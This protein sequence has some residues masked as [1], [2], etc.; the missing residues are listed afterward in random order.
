MA[1]RMVCASWRMVAAVLLLGLLLAGASGQQPQ[2]LQAQGSGAAE[3]E[4]SQWGPCGGLNGPDKRDA[5][6]EGCPDGYAC[7]RQD[8]FYWQVMNCALACG[9]GHAVHDQR[10]R[11]RRQSRLVFML[12]RTPPNTSAV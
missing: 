8:Q 2:Q 10:M 3:D 11:C 7:I 9:D 6:G 4:A 1:A 5:A 12:N